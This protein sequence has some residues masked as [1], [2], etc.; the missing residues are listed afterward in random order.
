MDFDPAPR[1]SVSDHVFGQLRDAILSG[2][3]PAGDPLPSERE[4]A[5][6]F[7]VNRHA[8]REALRRL[9]Q[10]G[11]VRVS[12][13]GATRVL[14]W[15]ATAGLDLAMALTAAGDVLP[16]E[17][18]A[19]DVLE[20]RACIGADAARLCALRASDAAKQRVSEA[21]EAYAAAV[22]D[23]AAMGPADLLL[24]RRIVE[25][26]GNIAYLLAFNSLAA[27]ALAVGHVPPHLRTEE[28]L[29]VAAHRRLAALIG[30]GAAAE[31]EEAARGLLQVK[32]IVR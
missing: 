2:G 6:T 13:G 8:V 24:W 10:L 30:A 17:S 23:L 20:M 32:E 19:R 7:E 9:Q 15:R 11:L 16:V 1:R 18:L 3:C 28:L 25:G 29:N 12:Q 27:G 21:V 14:D 31:A 26:S 22:P 5:T 4:L